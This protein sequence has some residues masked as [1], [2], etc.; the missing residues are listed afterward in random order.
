MSKVRAPTLTAAK[1]LETRRDRDIGF[2]A[3][4]NPRPIR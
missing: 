3:F 1:I 4:L 2:R